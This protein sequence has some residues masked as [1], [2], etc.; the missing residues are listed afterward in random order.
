VKRDSRSSDDERKFQ[1]V[2]RP[3]P[4][5]PVE[6]EYY[7]RRDVREVGGPRRSDEDF[8]EPL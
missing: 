4:R 7:Y 3:E 6:D 5:R 8:A 1:E 2:S